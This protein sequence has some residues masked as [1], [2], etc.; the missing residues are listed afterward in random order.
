MNFQT[1]Q[2]SNPRTLEPSASGSAHALMLFALVSALMMYGW[3]AEGS[4][5]EPARSSPPAA[6]ETTGIAL[7]PGS[8]VLTPCAATMDPATHALRCSHAHAGKHLRTSPSASVTLLPSGLVHVLESC[9]GHSEKHERT[10]TTCEGDDPYVL[11]YV[12]AAPGA[13]GAPGTGGLPCSSA[14]PYAESPYSPDGTPNPNNPDPTGAFSLVTRHWPA[15]VSVHYIINTPPGA[16]AGADIFA[17]PGG[18]P[19]LGAPYSWT[20]FANDIVA[21]MS[22]VNTLQLADVPTTVRVGYPPNPSSTPD[23]TPTYIAGGGAIAANG[24]FIWALACGGPTGNGLNEFIFLPPTAGML[25]G[26]AG[27]LSSMLVDPKTG[28][29]SECDTIYEAA[30]GPT[31]WNG[32]VTRTNSGLAH[33]VGH[34]WG[35]DHTNLHTGGATLNT[36]AAPPIPGSMGTYP[37]FN[38]VPAMTASFTTTISTTGSTARNRV[39]APWLPDD[40]AALA[41]LYPVSAMSSSKN[42]LINE[43]ASIVGSVADQLNAFGYNVFA[44]QDG[45]LVPLTAPLPGVPLVGTIS[46]TYRSGPHSVTGAIDTSA[47]A[48]STGEFRI[49]GIPTSGSANFAL[50]IEPLDRLGFGITSGMPTAT[51]GEW[52]YEGV[53]NTLN[54][55]PMSLAAAVTYAGYWDNNPTSPFPMPV[56]SM[57]MASG[58]IIRLDN[59]IDMSLGT[60]QIVPMSRPLVEVSPRNSVPLGAFMTITVSHNRAAAGAG[61]PGSNRPFPLQSLTCKWNGTQLPT[62]FVASTTASGPGGGTMYVSVYSVAVPANLPQPATVTVLALEVPDLANPLIKSVVG[63]NQVRY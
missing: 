42:F 9:G 31:A 3:F 1:D 56:S 48:V 47:G 18:V 29:I 36:T 46:G 53:L 30:A 19:L 55:P 49:D 20:M 10:D 39:L 54:L 11:W 15:G 51:F 6:P 33:E 26:A 40:I 34:F 60:P 35:L 25:G 37:S 50:C 13:T 32:L 57:R 44:I 14:A 41:T 4:S 2:S 17:G 61:V 8:R 22:G 43:S 52:W 12:M 16:A 7:P 21:L 27:G 5:V 63:E 59:P 38:E 58:T 28:I 23:S 62:S 45:S 24:Q